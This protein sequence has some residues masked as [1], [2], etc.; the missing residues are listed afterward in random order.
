[1]KHDDNIPYVIVSLPGAVETPDEMFER[2]KVE[3]E[4]KAYTRVQLEYVYDMILSYRKE[5][6]YRYLSATGKDLDMDCTQLLLGY[7][8]PDHPLFMDCLERVNRLNIILKGLK[9][10]YHNYG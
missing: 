8:N 7:A 3:L 9:N 1:M 2:L 5:I 4:G 10:E 6:K